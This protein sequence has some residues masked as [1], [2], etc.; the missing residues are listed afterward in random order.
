I[1][2]QVNLVEF[3]EGSVSVPLQIIADKPESVKVFPNEVEIKYQ[4]PLADYDKVKSE[5]FRVS[6]VLN[7][8]SL[9]QS[10]LVVNIDRKPEEV[11]QVRVRPTQVEFIVQK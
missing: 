3:T 4:V 8:N 6:V 11:T 9:K 10:S 7:E 1:E 5:Q 2:V